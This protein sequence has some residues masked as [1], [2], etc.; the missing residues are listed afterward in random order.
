M[1]NRLFRVRPAGVRPPKRTQGFS[2]F[3]LIVVVIVIGVLFVLFANRIISYQELAE[4]AAMETTV[5]NLQSALN[6]QFAQIQTRGQS[7]DVD[8][9]LLDNPIKWLQKVPS[10]YA[11]EFYDASPR[12]VAPGRWL[13]DLK[14][15]E[16]IYVMQHTE[17]FHPNATGRLW[18]RFHA[19][20]QDQKSVLVSLQ[21]APRQLTAVLFEPVEPYAWY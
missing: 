17:H 15:R 3:E 18:I 4:K 10:N 16:L 20:R 2:L 21:D 14:S 9:L 1:M 7:S 19:L 11:G 12:S 6:L 5:G 8:M 13:F